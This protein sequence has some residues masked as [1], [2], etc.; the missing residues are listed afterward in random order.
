VTAKKIADLEDIYFTVGNV[1][2]GVL[3]GKRVS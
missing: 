1:K 2:N 3:G